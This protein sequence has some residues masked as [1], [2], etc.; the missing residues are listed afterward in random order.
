MKKDILENVYYRLK[1]E[2][3]VKLSILYSIK[4]AGAPV[5]DTEIKHFMLDATSVSFVDLCINL[6]SLLDGGYLKSVWR[7]EIEK[8][9]LTEQGTE[10]IEMFSD[11]I[12][13][14][15]RESL[16]KSIDEYLG[17]DADGISVLA[18]IS[19]ASGE[20]FNVNLEIK[21]QKDTLLSLS[22]FAGE[23]KKAIA[24]RKHFEKNATDIF[25]QVL[26][27]AK[28]TEESEDEI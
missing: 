17:R 14:T 1:D 26:E 21:N 20:N 28:P 13:V 24:M 8:Y 11:K 5:S 22:V 27:I 16:R 23:R 10:L 4:Y 3:E 18:V 6:T 25:A 2:H 9:D 12:M 7:D 15:V 19:P